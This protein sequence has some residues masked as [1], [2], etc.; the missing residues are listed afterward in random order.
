VTAAE[1]DQLERE[2]LAEFM[3]RELAAI[4]TIIGRLEV[5]SFL[6]KGWTVAL[7]VVAL[8][9]DGPR[10]FAAL[11]LVPILTFWVLDAYHVWRAHMYGKLHEWV[12]TN[13][14]QTYEH[15]FDTSVHIFREEAQ[16]MPRIMFSVRVGWFYGCLFLFSALY[17]LGSLLP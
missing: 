1:N 17:V 8:L 14:L 4:Q 11:G 9:L 5:K 13:R 7:V 10:P 16:S 3:V 15:L 2:Q 12:A 6:I